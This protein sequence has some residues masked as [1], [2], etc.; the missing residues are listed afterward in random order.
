ML[1]KSFSRRY[2]EIFYL[3]ILRPAKT[4]CVCVYLSVCPFGCPSVCYVLFPAGGL[5]VCG[6]GG[7]VGAAGVFNKSTAY[8]TFFLFFPENRILTFH[9]SFLFW[10]RLARAVKA[11]FP[12]KYHPLFVCLIRSVKVNN[13]IYLRNSERQ[14]RA[15]SVDPDRRHRTQRMIMNVS[16][17]EE[18]PL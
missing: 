10:R 14:V 7:G 15:N 5:G 12:G 3:I 16:R 11:C 1:G 17:T 18:Q 8:L 2:F 13:C 4:V 9:A 6:G